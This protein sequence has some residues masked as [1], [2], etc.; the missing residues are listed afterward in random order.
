MTATEGLVK[1]ADQVVRVFKPDTQPDQTL[2]DASDVTRFLRNAR[3]RRRGRMT[4][5][6]FRST[7]RDRQFEDLHVVEDAERQC[8][9]VI[10]DEGKGR[11]GSGALR[12]IDFGRRVA[13]RHFGMENTGRDDVVLCQPLGNGAPAFCCAFHQQ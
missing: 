11:A 10:D 12:L 3:M 2:G 9:V 8:P 7:E 5:K 1:V 13:F 4:H 6:R